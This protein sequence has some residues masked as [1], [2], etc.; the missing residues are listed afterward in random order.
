MTRINFYIIESS[1][2][3]AVQQLV[4]RL[5][6]KAWTQKN[7]IYIHTDSPESA[8]ELDDYLWTYRE[9]SFIPHKLL[10]A[11]LNDESPV[12]IGH[13]NEK[14]ESPEHMHDVLINTSQAIPAFF[15]RFNRVAEIIA[16]DNNSREL[17]RERFRFYRDRGY[18]L[19]THKLSL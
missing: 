6:D 18:A 12:I 3:Q 9:D 15:S 14:A 2:L 7:T 4:C 16:A 10:D 17:G 5:T 19:E 1:D 8:G 13:N 11:E